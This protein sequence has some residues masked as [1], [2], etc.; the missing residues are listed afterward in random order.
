MFSRIMDSDS[1][2]ERPTSQDGTATKSS[3]YHVGGR[4]RGQ[5]GQGAELG[6]IPK[7]PI[8]REDTPKPE[9]QLQQSQVAPITPVKDEAPVTPAKAE[10]HMPQTTQSREDSKGTPAKDETS[11][12]P[13]AAENTPVPDIRAETSALR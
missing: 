1:H 12:T 13:A 9:S 2:I 11:S 6:S 7:N 10:T 8:H 5:S 3:W 4:K